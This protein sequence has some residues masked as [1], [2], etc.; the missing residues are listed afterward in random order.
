[1]TELQRT[2]LHAQL[3]DELIKVADDGYLTEGL[4]AATVAEAFEPYPDDDDFESSTVLSLMKSWGWDSVG[5]GWRLR[6]TDFH[7]IRR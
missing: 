5:Q 4:W 7:E 1:M 2:M 3:R 6:N